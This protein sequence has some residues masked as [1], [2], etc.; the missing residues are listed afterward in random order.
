MAVD[1]ELHAAWN[2]RVRGETQLQRLDRN[3]A[4]LLQELRVAQTG[5]QILFAF[6]LTLAFTDRFTHVSPFQRD[7]YIAALMLTLAS[8]GLLIAPVAYHRLTVR[9]RMRPQ[10]VSLAGILMLG[11]LTFLMLALCASIFF[12]TDVVVGQGAAVV[13]T[14]LAGGWLLTFWYLLPGVHR[15]MHRN[16]PDPSGDVDDPKPET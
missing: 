1:S 13:L 14:S 16:D 7:V 9:Q 6:L 11:G 4:E 12:I 5:V 15:M 3:F 8:T 10:L 2:Q